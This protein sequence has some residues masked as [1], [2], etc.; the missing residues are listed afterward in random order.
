MLATAYSRYPNSIRLLSCVSQRK[1]VIPR[2]PYHINIIIKCSTLSPQPITP[3]LFH[4]TFK[5]KF[6]K[7]IHVDIHSN[8]GNFY[9]KVKPDEKPLSD[10]SVK[11]V[12]DFLKRWKRE[13]YIIILLS[14][15]DGI[16]SLI[17]NYENTWYIPTGITFFVKDPSNGF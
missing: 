3:E 14:Q 10:T 4:D 2:H 13:E 9:V 1:N 6:G 15:E 17:E 7:N 5:L 8:Y 11:K 12:Y 16:S